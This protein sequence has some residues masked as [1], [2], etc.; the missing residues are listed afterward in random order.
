MNSLIGFLGE[1]CGGHLLEE[2]VFVVP[3]Y[4]VE[5]PPLNRNR[6]ELV[7]MGMDKEERKALWWLIKWGM[8]ENRDFLTF[9]NLEL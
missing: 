3:S 6:T 4:Q 2:K 7:T 5:H 8:H 9:Y 1:F